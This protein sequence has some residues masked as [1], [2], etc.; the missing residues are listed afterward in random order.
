MMVHRG[1]SGKRR[2]PKKK[3]TALRMAQARG[4]AIARSPD[5]SIEDD[6]LV[7][8]GVSFVETPNKG[9]DLSPRYL[10]FHYTAGKS[11]TSSIDWLTNPESKASA[12]LVLARDG[13]ITQLAP[14]D[15]KTW[16]AG[17]SHWDGLSGLNS[18]SIGI[19]MDNAGPLKKVGDKYQAWF[20]TLYAEDQVVFAKHKLDDEAHW[21]HAYTEVQ[22]QK[23]L[24]LAQLLVRH[25]DLKD[26]VGHED[27]VPDRKRDPGPAFPLEHVRAKVLG[28]EEE[29][30]ERY[31]VTASTLNIRS[32]PGVEFPPVA[33]PL[34][35]GTA[36]VLLEKRD[37]WFKVELVKNGD[38][39][40][41]VHNQFL[42]RI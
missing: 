5:L 22:I 17:I 25:Y 10:V 24:E 38:I 7:G 15:I 32:G 21:W 2:T 40:G 37:R 20:G 28:R 42:A 27:I 3:K 34:K 6:R 14:F 35:R 9:G 41:W 36:V 19:E 11:A 39:E 33:E 18:Y 26:V 12:H 4:I 16:H 23:A 31:D 29:E 8:A 13:T 30:R 1:P